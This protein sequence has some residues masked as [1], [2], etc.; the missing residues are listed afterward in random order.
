MGA[1]PW[2]FF[3]LLQIGA[4]APPVAFGADPLAGHAAALKDERPRDMAAI[5]TGDGE[6]GHV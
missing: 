1:L 6:D 2:M 5:R 4:C 3:D